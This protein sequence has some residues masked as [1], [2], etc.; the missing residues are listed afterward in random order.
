MKEQ[1]TVSVS[2]R[3]C[4]RERERVSSDEKAIKR[5][6]GVERE[7]PIPEPRNKNDPDVVKLSQGR[8][9]GVMKRGLSL[10]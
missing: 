10:I 1:D 7:G 3:V 9:G 4:V 8:E 5:A 6:R 2:T